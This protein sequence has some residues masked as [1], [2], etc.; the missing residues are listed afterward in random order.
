MVP[1]LPLE[2]DALER[3]VPPELEG[4]HDLPL[5]AV[6]RS[7]DEVDRRHHLQDGLYLGICALLWPLLQE[8]VREGA[9]ASFVESTWLRYLEGHRQADASGRGQECGEKGMMLSLLRKEY[10]DARE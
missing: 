3:P 4:L 5:E 8:T 10:L 2:D 9:F 6:A 1:E 7:V